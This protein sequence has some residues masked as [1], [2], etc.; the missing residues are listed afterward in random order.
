MHC[1]PFRGCADNDGVG[2]EFSGL[3][4]SAGEAELSDCFD[5]GN[6]AYVVCRFF[7]E[8]RFSADVWIECAEVDFSGYDDKEV[9]S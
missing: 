2:I 1:E 6:F 4:P 7:G 9:R 5:S 3:D 8:E